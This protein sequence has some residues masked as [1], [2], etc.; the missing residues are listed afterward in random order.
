VLHCIISNLIIAC[1][2]CLF[3]YSS[4]AGEL[5]S[6]ECV[7]SEKF[8][9]SDLP[10]YYIGEEGDLKHYKEV[11]AYAVPLIFILLVQHVFV[12]E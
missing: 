8:M 11:R 5:I 7:H 9:L 6:E 12:V 1:F 2:V 10:D 3:F 4:I